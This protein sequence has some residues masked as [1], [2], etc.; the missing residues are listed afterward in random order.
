M[1]VTFWFAE[2]EV[3]RFKLYLI[4]YLQRICNS[5]GLGKSVSTFTAVVKRKFPCTSLLYVVSI[6][7]T[8][9]SW[10][11]ITEFKEVE[12]D[13]PTDLRELP[14]ASCRRPCSGA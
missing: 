4:A 2:T 6:G 8:L 12:G 7:L 13:Q 14:S 1:L 9:G 11:F 10:W 3:K 5:N